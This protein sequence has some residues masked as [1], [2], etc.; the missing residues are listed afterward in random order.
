[1]PRVVELDRLSFGPLRVDFVLSYHHSQLDRSSARYLCRCL[2]GVPFPG[3]ARKRR[4]S[5]SRYTCI[6]LA[7]VNATACT[8]FEVSWYDTSARVPAAQEVES[9]TSARAGEDP[10]GHNGGLIVAVA[11]S[12]C[13]QCGRPR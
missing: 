4:P 5:R 1:M 7:A 9:P 8:A 13:T 10:E 12:P 3:T 6:I 11:E 2:H